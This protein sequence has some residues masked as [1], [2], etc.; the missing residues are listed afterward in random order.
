MR[1]IVPYDPL[2]SCGLTLVGSL[3]K[4]NFALQI[5]NTNKKVIV[6]KGEGFKTKLLS[7]V[8]AAETQNSLRGVKWRG[9]SVPTQTRQG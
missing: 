4:R 6:V 9:N 8:S 5:P 3:R 7:Q 1:Y 2:A